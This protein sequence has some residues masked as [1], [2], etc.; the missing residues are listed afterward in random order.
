M[1]AMA[2]QRLM[3]LDTASLYFR[4]FYGVPSSIKAP[5]GTPVNAVR[6]LLDF[7]SRLVADHQPTDLIAA[8][9]DDWRPDFRVAAIP[10]YKAHRVVDS[11]DDD[12]DGEDVPDELS[13]QVAL[14]IEVLELIGIARLGAPGY[15]ADDVIGSLVAQSDYPVLVVTGDRDL[16]QLVDDARPVRVLYT[17]AKGVGNAEVIDDAAIRER[18]GVAASQ[19]GDY[20]LLRGDTSDG[21]P[22]VRGIGEKTAASMISEFGD[23]DSLVA[24]VQAGSSGV[25]A[26]AQRNLLAGLDYIDR[27]R[28]VVRVA[29]DIDLAP[30]DSA[31]PTK[32][33]HP[34]ELNEFATRWGLGG[35]IGRLEVAFGWGHQ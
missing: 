18:Y 14:I 6:G 25:K 28:D 30:V 27:A 13:H 19:Y 34:V 26:G 29:P 2:T 22:G 9:D 5:D 10:S 16:F 3:V 8:W 24:A 4:A 35:A 21:L 32:P 11:S 7:I 1:S 15:E 17:A 12:G 31:L 23:I 20:A 33:A